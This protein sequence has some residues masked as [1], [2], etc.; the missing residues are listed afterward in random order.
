MVK[1]T[2]TLHHAIKLSSQAL[3]LGYQPDLNGGPQ[4]G[5]DHTHYNQQQATNITSSSR[6]TISHHCQVMIE[7]GRDR[8]AIYLKW[9]S[10]LG[11]D[12]LRGRW[13]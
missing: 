13:L 1:R 8:Q 2:E 4:Q 5:K 11:L 3:D 12:I 10:Q 7:R 6:V 9:L